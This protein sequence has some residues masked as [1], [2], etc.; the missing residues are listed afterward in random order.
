MTQGPEASFKTSINQIIRSHAPN[1][2]IE[3]MANPYN[4]GTPDVYYEGEKKIL[5]VEYKVIKHWPRNELNIQKYLSALQQAWI[6]RANFNNV[7]V[8]V[9]VGL[10]DKTGI[11]Y[12][13]SSA[14]HIRL[15][16]EKLIT[17]SLSRKEIALYVIRHT[18]GRH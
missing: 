8:C 13:G 15:T 9:I 10:P 6:I 17:Q 7:D 12:K 16:K 18:T 1:V 2:H 14:V 11:I 5:W 4:N 3:G